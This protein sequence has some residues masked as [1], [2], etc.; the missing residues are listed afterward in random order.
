[1]IPRNHFD[2]YPSPWLYC[3]N[4][5]RQVNVR[6]APQFADFVPAIVHF[7]SHLRVLLIIDRNPVD[8]KVV[9]I[10]YNETASRLSSPFCVTEQR[11]NVRFKQRSGDIDDQDDSGDNFNDGP[12]KIGTIA[13]IT[14]IMYILLI[15]SVILTT[16]TASIVLLEITFV[17]MVPVIRFMSARLPFSLS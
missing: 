13:Q 2:M 6:S 15:R 4:C 16:P 10:K 12:E 8:T 14:R 3:T 5:K 17:M 9:K 11:H 1:M 7:I